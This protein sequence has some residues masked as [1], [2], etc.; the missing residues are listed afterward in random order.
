[1]SLVDFRTHLAASVLKGSQ[2]V[3]SSFVT[4]IDFCNFLIQYFF[5][6]NMFTSLS[7]T[8]KQDFATQLSVLAQRAPAN[9]SPLQLGNYIRDDIIC[10][11]SEN[12]IA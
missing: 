12:K 11:E 1:M 6:Q 2:N 5:V 3:E 4:P 9:S 7:S 10:P 8:E